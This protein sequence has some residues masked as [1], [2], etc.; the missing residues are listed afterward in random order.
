MVLKKVL[1]LHI[2]EK[3][4]LS[5]WLCDSVENNEFLDLFLACWVLNIDICTNYF[6]KILNCLINNCRSKVANRITDTLNSK[7]YHVKLCQHEP[8]IHK[9][10]VTTMAIATLWNLP[11]IA[12]I[13]NCPTTSDNKVKYVPVETC[14]FCIFSCRKVNSYICIELQCLIL[15][16]EVTIDHRG[17]KHVSYNWNKPNFSTFRHVLREYKVVFPL[18]L[19]LR[20]S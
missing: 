13:L 11:L 5:S 4:K 14:H 8:L 20:H 10:S 18:S 12:H 16:K 6:N 15:D 17:R 7:W 19:L 9:L 3:I 2:F 1:I